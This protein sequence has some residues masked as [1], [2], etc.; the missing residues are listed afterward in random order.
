VICRKLER[1]LS[2]GTSVLDFADALGL[3]RSVSGYSYHSVPIALFAWLR[4]PG[5]F[6]EALTS[7][8]N[9]G[10]DTDTM[11]AI[12]GALAGA[13]VRISGIPSEWLNRICEWP[14]SLKV[15][16]R[17]AE[18]LARQNK[19]GKPLDPIEYFWPALAPRNLAFLIVVLAHGFRRLAPPY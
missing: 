16:D 17:A 4:F 12:V 9:C 11:G 7:A 5:D 1:G 14:R 3:R 18:R 6:R 15:M 19:V 13:S 2:K 8:L 10:G